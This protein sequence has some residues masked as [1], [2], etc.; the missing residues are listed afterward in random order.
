M[1]NFLKNNKNQNNKDKNNESVEYIFNEITENAA[2][3]YKS[4]VFMY[5]LSESQAAET[6][7]ASASVQ[8]IS[9]NSEEASAQNEKVLNSFEVASKKLNGSV[10][11]FK[12]AQAVFYIFL[13]LNFCFIINCR[14]YL[15][16]IKGLNC[17][18]KK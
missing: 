6:E 8:E 12:K 15:A 2:E 13:L 16:K 1:K 11:E 7:E 18:K 17:F 14:N 3:V 9:A 10:S 4:M 5:E